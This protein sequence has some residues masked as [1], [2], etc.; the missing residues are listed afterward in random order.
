MIACSTAGSVILAGMPLAFHHAAATSS[1]G[2]GVIR[3]PSIAA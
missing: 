2:A 1:L 3:A